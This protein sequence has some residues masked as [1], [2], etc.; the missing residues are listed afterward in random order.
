VRARRAVLRPLAAC[1]FDSGGADSPSF[2]RFLA[3]RPEAEAFARFMATCER[4]GEAWASWPVGPRDG[5]IRPGDYDERARQYH[6]YVQWLLDGQLGTLAAGL[7]ERGQRLY[8][9]MPLGVHPAGYDVWSRRG[10]FATG[11]SAG[12]PPD[13]FFSLGQNWGFPPLHPEALRETRYAYLIDA[14]RTSFR[15]AGMLRIDHVMALHRVFWV[16]DGMEAAEGVYVRYPAHELYAIHCLESVRHASVVVGEDLG[17][18]PTEVRRAM[19]R[20]GFQRM[21]VLE[22]ETSPDRVPP[23]TSPVPGS[24][25]SVGTHDTPTFAAFWEALDV[26]DREDLGLLDAGAAAAEREGRAKLREAVI[27][28]L[29]DEGWLDTADPSTL[30]ALRACLARMAA[31]PA[32]LLLVN[33]E[34]LW[35]E[36]APQNVPGTSI[37]RPNWRRKARMTFNEFSGLPEVV[38]TLAEIQRLRS[39]TG[40]T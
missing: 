12:S 27:R 26:T 8:L 17:T 24:V 28:M 4:R 33:L 39:R 15:F 5:T 16:P 25:A 2:R 6:L 32:R 10:I 20:H 31:G 34:D 13:A 35:G 21:W 3:E 23:V 18:V 9:D 29:R 36:V 11:A 19:A 40:K 1:F 7:R 30:Q 14:L 22:F 38:D 37:E